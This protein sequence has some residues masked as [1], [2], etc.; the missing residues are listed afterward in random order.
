MFERIGDSWKPRI[1]SFKITM[2]ILL[3]SPASALGLVI[4]IIYFIIALLDQVDPYILGI[5]TNV[6]TLIPN[7]V[8]TAPQPPSWLSNPWD[9]SLPFGTTYPGINLY[10]GIIKAIRIDIAF[11]LFVVVTG[12]LIGIVL[13]VFSAFYGGWFDEII[14]RLT[15]IFFSIPYL[16][17]VIALGVFLGRS[18]LILSV[19]L[20]I[21][22]WPIYA[23]VVRGQALSIKEQTYVEAAR[24]AGVKNSRIILKHVLPNTMAP[25]FVQFSFDLATIVL[26]LATLYFIGFAPSNSWLPELGFLSSIGYEYAIVGDWWTIV[27]PG[28]ALMIFALGMNLL[29]DGLRDALDP[30][31]RR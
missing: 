15:D 25:I 17:L 12:A 31:L 19:G 27:F 7:Y 8:N 23:R 4:V 14:M 18:L 6:N 26:A 5:T 10:D 28:F 21:L 30:R 9:F 24:A 29:G 16:V 22:W 1:E 20:I 11:S 3:R 2:R 13:G